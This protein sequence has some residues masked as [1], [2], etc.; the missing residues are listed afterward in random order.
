PR[1]DAAVR[2][3]YA[4]AIAWVLVGI[5]AEIPASVPWF[6]GG[7]LTLSGLVQPAFVGWFVAIAAA[8]ALAWH[9]G[10]RGTRWAL[11]VAVCLLASTTTALALGGDRW[12]Q[13][14]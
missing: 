9:L 8:L 3:A 2:G 13:T 1:W 10:P 7:W 5:R 4:L 11:P 6:M 14:A 12:R